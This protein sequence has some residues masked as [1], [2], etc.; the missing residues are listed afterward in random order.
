MKRLL[1][2]RRRTLA[3]VA[4]LV[5]LLALFSYVAFRSGPLAPI[6]V[7][8]AVVENRSLMP[9][10]FGIGT[11]ESRYTYKI[12]PTVAGRV[13]RVDVNPGDIVR[14]GQVL[15]EMDAVDLDARMLAEDAVVRRA[16]EAVRSSDAQVRDVSAR[17][18]YAEAQAR[19]HEQLWRAQLVSEEVVEAQRRELE[20]AE[21]SVGAALANLGAARQQLEVSRASRRGLTRQRA[22]FVLTAPVN[23]LVASRDADPGTT[24]VAGQAVLEVIDAKSLWINARFDQIRSSG[25]RPTLPA[26]VVLRAGGG[27]ELPG[28]VLRVEPVADAVTEETLAKIVFDSLPEPLPPIGELVEVTVVLPATPPARV[29]PSASVQR[30]AGRLGVW[31]IADGAL[32]F[33]P[34]RVGASDLDGWVQI[35]DGLETGD[36]VV[37]YSQRSLSAGK[38]VNVVDRLEGG[39]R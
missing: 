37:V 19:R 17:R 10:L 7:T 11:V 22:S 35:L 24:V 12:G 9:E 23:G 18:A 33:A 29:V 34:V 6:P 2:M 26:R 1:S 16:E 8:V 5:P 31:M 20:V 15:G 25:L 30:V 28:R 21:A 14:A 4:V 32:R 38:R 39:P 13:L 3:L 36:R 27:H